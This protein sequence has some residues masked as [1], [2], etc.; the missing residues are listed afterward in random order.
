[1]STIDIS[2][3]KPLALIVLGA[4]CLAAAPLLN[5]IG[6]RQQGAVDHLRQAGLVTMGSVVDKV[7]KGEVRK[8]VNGKPKSATSAMLVLQYDRN[9]QM[10]WADFVA[11]NERVKI[12]LQTPSMNTYAR[13]AS[14]DEFKEAKVGDRL[15]L[16]V[17][18]DN[19]E[20]VETADY[21]K[22]YKSGGLRLAAGGAL[23]LGLLTLLAG[24]GTWIKGRKG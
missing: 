17:D 23:L 12:T 21:V 7:A 4:L 22:T 8:G 16:V 10:A 11:N 14:S 6:G 18:P 15:A 19:R 2:K 20:K 1:M 5:F 24:V 3:N 13:P 9:A